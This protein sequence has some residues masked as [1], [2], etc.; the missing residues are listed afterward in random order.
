MVSREP[1]SGGKGASIRWRGRGSVGE[2]ER[3]RECVF[4]VRRLDGGGEKG[5]PRGAGTY[6]EEWRVQ[7]ITKTKTRSGPLSKQEG[8]K[9][10]TRKNHASPKMDGKVPWVEEGSGMTVGEVHESR[11]GCGCA[12][13]GGPIQLRAYGSAVSEVFP[14]LAISPFNDPGQS[15]FLHIRGR[16]EVEA[17]GRG[18]EKRGRDESRGG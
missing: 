11:K 5:R 3:P 17:G 4:G 18:C 7:I 10:S 14:Y 15:L 12:H 9:M 6:E 8:E 2:R 13:Y 16:H 1:T